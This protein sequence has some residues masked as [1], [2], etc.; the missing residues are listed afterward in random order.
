MCQGCDE[1]GD[2]VSL[3]SKPTN[4]WKMQFSE[5]FKIWLNN[6]CVFKK[7]DKSECP[8]RNLK[9]EYFSAYEGINGKCFKNWTQNKIYGKYFW[10]AS[11]SHKRTIWNHQLI[12]YMHYN[13]FNSNSFV[14]RPWAIHRLTDQT[15]LKVYKF[16]LEIPDKK[17]NENFSI[18]E[19]ASAKTR[20]NNETPKSKRLEKQQLK[21]TITL[22]ISSA[23]KE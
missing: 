8:Q 12:F 19:F 1:R 9:N 7:L 20:S 22:N 13:R 14:T 11:P 2:F 5:I 18:I 21:A 16:A 15:G 3:K 23:K 6:F 17:L 4:F 10:I